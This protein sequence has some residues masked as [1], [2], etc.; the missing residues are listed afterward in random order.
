MTFPKTVTIEETPLSDDFE[1]DDGDDEDEDSV[2]VKSYQQ[3]YYGRDE[4]EINSW[5]DIRK[6]WKPVDLSHQDQED[7]DDYLNSFY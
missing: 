3:G 5:A 7:Y 1:N 6:G 2:P 4:Q